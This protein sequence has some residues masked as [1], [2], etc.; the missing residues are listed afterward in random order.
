MEGKSKEEKTELTRLI[1]SGG[2]EWRFVRIL[3]PLLFGSSPLAIKDGKTAELRAIACQATR[4]ALHSRAHLF[5]CMHLPPDIDSI[6]KSARERPS[7]VW[8]RPSPA[9]RSLRDERSDQPCR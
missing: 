3:L 1:C 8:P 2:T 7:L 4:V 5:Q 6:H 9:D